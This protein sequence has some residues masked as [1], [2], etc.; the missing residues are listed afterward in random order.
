MSESPLPLPGIEERLERGEVVYFE[1][2]PFPL[3]QGDDRTFLLEQTLASRAHK[4][5]SY[6]PQTGKASGY[7]HHSADQ[8]ERLRAMLAAFAD[9]VTT[10]AR[11]ALPRYAAAWKKDK[12][13]YR[14]VEEATRKARL[15]A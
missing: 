11:G 3:P 8:S 7:T 1:S 15:K 5:V 14:P 2:C 9:G 13:S 10:W 6:D 4:N 12:V